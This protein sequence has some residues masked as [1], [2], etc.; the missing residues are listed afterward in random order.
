MKLTKGKI[1]KLYNKK[2]QSFKKPKGKKLSNKR[3]TFR[4]KKHLNL[5]RKTLKRHNYKKRGGNISQEIPLETRPLI[6]SGTSYK[7]TIDNVVNPTDKVNPVDTEDNAVK[8]TDKVTTPVD[9]EDNVVSPTDEVTTPVDTEENAVNPT[10]E[11]TTPVNTEE[12]KDNVTDEDTT[13]DTEENVEQPTEQAA[14]NSD[15]E[16]TNEPT[17]LAP[18]SQPAP[19]VPLTLEDALKPVAELFAES[20]AEPVANLVAEKLK[21]QEI[22]AEP[23]P[24]ESVTETAQQLASQNKNGGSK[25]KKSK[26]F[27]L[28]KKNKTKKM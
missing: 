23:N 24:F 20:L 26:K 25:I 27:R 8:P 13:V 7:S 14:E 10:D 6:N 2:R 12:K 11:D 3:R 9:T 5:A 17:E 28:T 15:K 16:T 1:T 22:S 21:P 4:N 19:K 18:F